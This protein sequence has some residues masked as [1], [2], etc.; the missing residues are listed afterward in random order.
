LIP[1]ELEKLQKKSFEKIDS[2][3]IVLLLVDA[4]S[5]SAQQLH[6]DVTNIKSR[7]A[8]KNKRLIV[9]ANKIDKSN[10]DELKTKFEGIENVIYIAAKE[11]QNIEQIKE[12]LYAFVKNGLLQNTDVVV[13][14]ARHYEALS[15]ANAS[16][17]KV[18]EGLDVNITG[19]FLAMDIRQALHQLGVITGEI[20]IDD[21]LDNIFSKF[22]IGK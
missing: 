16:L 10:V 7:I 20:T 4:A 18:L 1:L 12:Q 14:N 22:C 21:L 17:I 8:G 19:D 2:A 5:I 6:T 13:T 9:V 3:S 11:Q 15:S